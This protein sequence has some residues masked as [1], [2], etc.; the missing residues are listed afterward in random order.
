MFAK[1]A[2]PWSEEF[3]VKK[4]TFDSSFVYQIDF[5]IKLCLFVWSISFSKK[6]MLCFIIHHVLHSQC[7]E[8]F[9]WKKFL[10]FVLIWIISP[11]LKKIRKKR[12]RRLIDHN[13]FEAFERLFRVKYQR[14]FQDN[15]IILSQTSFDEREKNF[16]EQ[17]RRIFVTNSELSIPQ[18]QFFFPFPKQFFE[19]QEFLKKFLRAKFF[20][21]L[22]FEKDKGKGKFFVNSQ[23]TFPITWNWFEDSFIFEWEWSKSKFFEQTCFLILTVEMQAYFFS[24]KLGFWWGWWWLGS[25]KLEKFLVSSLWLNKVEKLYSYF[26]VWWRSSSKYSRFFFAAKIV[27]FK[28]RNSFQMFLMSHN[29][30]FVFF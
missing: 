15:S 11:N 5:Y 4:N 23:V 17:K 27:S 28:A 25:L 9:I 21:S 29:L 8:T 13:C 6:W 30:L 14:I 1:N 22:I 19:I 26:A 3:E 7:M 10:L 16:S 12:K 2:F 20:F 24:L 18:P